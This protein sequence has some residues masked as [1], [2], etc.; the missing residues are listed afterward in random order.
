MKNYKHICNKY[1]VYVPNE[2]ID[3]KMSVNLVIEVI[4]SV[5]EEFKVFYE[6]GGIYR[7]S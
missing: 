3:K 4:N 1:L 6:K 2:K 7:I 5:Y